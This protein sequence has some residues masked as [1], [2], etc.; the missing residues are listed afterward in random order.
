MKKIL[1]AITI[2]SF[3]PLSTFADTSLAA[4]LSGQIL[5]QVEAHGE[6]WYINP[7][8]NKRYFLG[9]PQD[10]FELMKKLSLG[11]SNADLNKIVPRVETGPIDSDGDGYSDEI[12]IKNNYNPFGA[13]KLNIDTA[14]TTHHLGKIF[15]QTEK[16]G[17][18]WYVNPSD[19]RRY[20]LNRPCD[21]FTIM[22]NLGLGISNKNLETIPVGILYNEISTP[23]QPVETPSINDPINAAANAIRNGNKSEAVKYFIPTMKKAIEYTVDFL[24]AEGRLTL[25]NILSG[26]RLESSTET[27]K[28]YFNEVYFN[29]EKIPVRFYIEKIDGVWLMTNL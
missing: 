9:R 15:L 6:A 27:K 7:G 28:T 1:T 16:N 22:K 25:G 14:F 24:N 23:A 29:G 19:Q 18:A 3:L 5:I 26:S 4:K 21:A 13:G 20:F 12:E 2:L 10:A 8:D 17:Q 11:I